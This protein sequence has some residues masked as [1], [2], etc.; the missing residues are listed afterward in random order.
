[1]ASSGRLKP[2][3][4]GTITARV[5]TEAKKGVVIETVDVKSND[6][7]RPKVVLTLQALIMEPIPDANRPSQSK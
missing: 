1:M 3:E 5:A 2:G 4:K 7:K 6:P